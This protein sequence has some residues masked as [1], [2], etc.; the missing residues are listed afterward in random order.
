MLVEILEN[1]R[2]KLLGRE[3][4]KYFPRQLGNN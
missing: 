1:V 3:I 4:G 2:T